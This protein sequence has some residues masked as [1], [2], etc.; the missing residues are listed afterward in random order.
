MG[1]LG[2]HECLFMLL[3]RHP[4]SLNPV[5]HISRANNVHPLLH[6]SLPPRIYA[7]PEFITSEP[8]GVFP[9]EIL[10]WTGSSI[11][12]KEPK[13][14]FAF[15]W[16]IPKPFFSADR[17]RGGDGWQV[18]LFCILREAEVRWVEFNSILGTVQKKQQGTGWKPWTLSI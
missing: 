16:R 10:K 6:T 15:V 7:S 13:C 17:R 11:V 4:F 9:N 1:A 18:M 3:F 2:L 5:P 12:V 14:S 8:Q